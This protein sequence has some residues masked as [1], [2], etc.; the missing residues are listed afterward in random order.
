MSL[1]AHWVSGS[2]GPSGRGADGGSVSLGARWVSGSP[3]QLGDRDTS[4]TASAPGPGLLINSISVR[5]RE[6][7]KLGRPDVDWRP[8]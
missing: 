4:D 6:E 5:G 8:Q 3:N 1:G 2:P 7:E